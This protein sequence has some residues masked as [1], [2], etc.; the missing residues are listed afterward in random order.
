MLYEFNLVSSG[1]RG[2]LAAS[3]SS[4]DGIWQYCHA[5]GMRRGLMPLLPT[6]AFLAVFF[7]GQWLLG[8][9]T[10][11]HLA[12]SATVAYAGWLLAAFLVGTVAHELG[13]APS[14]ANR[15]PGTAWDHAWRQVR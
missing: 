2:V 6:L 12:T 13:H 15:R 3:R 4:M 1:R 5:L 7:G 8:I 10:P 11:Q 14:G 9:N